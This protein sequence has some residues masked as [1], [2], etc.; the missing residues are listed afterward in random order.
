MLN[1]V[2]VLDSFGFGG[3]NFHF[4]LEEYRATQTEPYRLNVVPETILVS[5]QSRAAL[6]SKLTQWAKKLDTD[7]DAA[8]FVFNALVEENPCT[9]PAQ[10]LARCG[11][12]AKNS[13]QAKAAIEQIVKRFATDNSQAWSLPTG[14][15]YRESALESAGKVVSLFSGQGSQYLNMGRELVCNFPPMLATMA[16]MDKA[17]SQAGREELSHCLYPIPVFSEQQRQEQQRLLQQTQ[18]AQPAIGAFSMGLYKTMQQAGFKSDFAAGHSFGELTAL[19]AAGVVSDAD[20]MRLARSRGEAMAAPLDN[21]FDAGTMI[22]VVGDPDLIADAIKAFADITI[23]N[24]NAN[25]QVVVAGATA[26]IASATS[27]LQAQGFKVV[28]LPVSGAFHTQLVNHAQQPFAEVIDSVE[29]H[30]PVIPVFSNGTAQLHENDGDAIKQSLKNHILQSVRFKEEIDNIYSA[31]GRIF[32]EFGPKNVLSRLVDNILA[33]KDDVTT[34]AINSNPKQSADLQLRLAAL[35]MAVLG[36]PLT[37][38]DPYNAVARPTVA[39]KKSPLAMKLSG[40]AYVS[41]KA[42]QAFSDALNDGWQIT[43]AAQQEKVVVKEVIVEKV[44]EK[45]VYVNADGTPFETSETTHANNSELVKS[46]EQSVAALIHQQSQLLDVHQEF[47][48]GPQ[49]YAKTYQDLL[50]IQSGTQAL[51]ESLDKTLSMYHQYQSETLRVHESYLNSQTENMQKVLAELPS[52]TASDNIGV[53]HTVNS[54]SAKVH[55]VEPVV[56]NSATLSI[57]EQLA[58]THSTIINVTPTVTPVV[59]EPVAPVIDT[60]AIENVMLAVVADK[61]GYPVEMLELSMDMEADLGIDSIKRVEILGAVQD[62]I[63]DLPELNPEALAE[64]RTLAEIVDYMNECAG[65]VAVNAT[66][67]AP[68]TAASID[69]DKIQSVMLAV[70]ADKTG[71]PVEMLELSMDMEADLGIDSIKRVEILGAVQDE[72]ADLPE[73]NAEALAELRTLAEIVDYMNQCAGTIAVN[74][75]VAAPQTA[76]AIDSDKI[77]SVMLAVVADKTGYPVEMLELSMDMEADLGIDSIKRVEIL[78]AVQDEIT[79]LPELN[80]EALAELRTLAEIVAY[81]NQCAGSV[82]VNATVAA[83][84]TAASIDSDK[85]Q[86]VMLSVVAD[87]T[88]YPVEMLELSMDMEADLGIDSI[89]RVEIL[90]A[91]QDEITDL[92]ELNAEALAELRTLAEIVAY[93]NQCAGSVAVNATVAAPQTAASIDSDKIQSVMLSVV[94]DKT[95]YPVEMLELSMDMEADLGIDSIKRV[96]ILGAVQDEITDLPELNAEA[97]A[98]QRTLADI[99]A[100]MAAVSGAGD[101]PKQ[102]LLAK[103]DEQLDRRVNDFQPA[104][105][106]IVTVKHLAPVNKI[107]SNV[108]GENLLLVD[109]GE[110]CTVRLAEQLTQLGWAVTL[111]QPAWVKAT[112]TK[113]FVDKVIVMPL[114]ELSEQEVSAILATQTSWTSVIYLHPKQA[115]AGLEY[116]EKSKQGLQLAFLLAKLSGLAQNNHNDTRSSFVVLTRQ[117]GAFGV[118]ENELD[119]DLVQSGLTGLVKTLNHEWPRVFCRA[120]DI[121]TKFSGDKVAK[122][123]IEELNDSDCSHVEVGFNHNGRLTLVAESTDSYALN[124]GNSIDQNSLFLVSGGAKGVT[125]HCVI[126]LAQKY[127]AKFILLG[128][129]HYQS[130]EPTWAN[131]VLDEVELKKAAMQA[132]IATGEKA[133]PNSVAALV[134]PILANREIKQTL[135]AIDDAGGLAEYVSADVTDAHSVMDAVS[136][137]TDL[138]GILA[139]LFTVLAC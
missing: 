128:R 45:I 129:S 69:S 36:L 66:V 101:T 109:D 100:Y 15:Y 97:L 73:L 23:A 58:K 11:F 91:V 27:A 99:V 81:M 86:S 82:A 62:E 112:S 126:R 127:R 107:E 24:Y 79:D 85:I 111:L 70:V 55:S 80:A 72:I 10:E 38:I 124:S 94:A 22:A 115:I 53:A 20:Y 116:P 1:V 30:S 78:G 8:Q 110:G 83:P 21:D 113:S 88:G 108:N 42:K 7:Q 19:W 56:N 130:E 102:P 71:Y 2:L 98:E 31:G 46:V 75:T 90:G 63:T 48:Q 51:P 59:A 41:P 14:I 3:T 57:A 9:T 12:A 28:A 132:I 49:E 6:I 35:Q 77:Q 5:A 68:Q 89:K 96:E 131:D 120:I 76:T 64:L 34:I 114:E 43:S 138:W 121:A 133:T 118:D 44:V 39:P 84:Q 103:I 33:D 54:T 117:G 105:S 134:K 60:K 52:V 95:G 37:T 65:T 50:L 106:A 125:A 139:V 136:P 123:I 40:A 13:Q 122:L 32:V 47:M 104:P 74:A 92:P 119:A 135:Q 67:A 87:K 25:N 61:T 16:E 26:Q 137:I 17:F 29:F 4:V 93:M 18:F